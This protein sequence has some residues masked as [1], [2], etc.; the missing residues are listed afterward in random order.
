MKFTKLGEKDI[1]C[2]I[3]ESELIDFG[4]NLDDII[5]RNGR[6]KEFF[7]QILDI[8]SKQLGMSK[9]D[10]LHL[11][12]AQ[13]SVLKDNSLSIIFH[14]TSVDEILDNLAGDDK[15]RIE[16]LKKSIEEA[17]KTDPKRLPKNIRNEIVNIMEERIKSEG[18]MTPAV[19]A[20][21]R[22]IR[23]EIERD[24][25][26]NMALSENRYKM[27][28]I[29]FVSLDDAI[30]YCAITNYPDGFESSL[31]KSKTEE[32]FFLVIS[33]NDMSLEK[34]SSILF[35][36]SEFGSV[37]ELSGAGRAFLISQSELMIEED[38][39]HKLKSLEE[40]KK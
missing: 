20:E 17:I 6:T 5:E 9:G 30:K 40:G 35:G 21:I 31:Y 26:N 4:L 14:E 8:G 2:V 27:C 29:R 32:E 28:V 16:K 13:I 3:S 1:R 24:E 25:A 33:R 38:A 22:Q 15:E 23:E 39:Y 10:G 34:Y 36:A 37:M 11:A 18:N 12:S 19:M 7:R